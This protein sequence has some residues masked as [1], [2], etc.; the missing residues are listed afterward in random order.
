MIPPL[1]RPY[2]ASSRSIALAGALAVTVAAIA[3]AQGITPDYYAGMRW[4]SI[5]P[6]RSGYVAAVAGIPGDPNTYYVG[7]P[8]GGVWKTTDGGTVWNPIFDSVHVA[9]VGAVAVAPS[10]PNTVYVGTGNSS[11]WSFTPGDGVYKSTDAGATWTNI[12]L[13][14]SQ[15][16][17]A[18]VVDPRQAN[19]VLVAVQGGRGAEPPG[20]HERGVYRSTDGGHDWTRVLGDDATGASDLSY[21]FDDPSIIY[22]TM[23][24]AGAGGRGGGAPAAPSGGASTGIYRSADGG[25]TWKPIGGKGLPPGAAGFALAVASGTHGNR[26]YG[27]VRGGA[28]GGGGPGGLYRSDDGGESWTLGTSA[29]ASAGGHIYADPKNPDV[30]YLMGTSMYRSLDGGKHFVS[31]MGAPSGAD[32]RLLWIDPT[33]PRRMIAGADQG[34]TIS[35]DGGETWNGWYNMRNGQFYRVSTDNDFPYHVCGPQQDSGDACVVSRSDFGQI[36]PSDWTP[37]GG[38]ENGFIATDPLNPRW[39]YDQG[40]YHVLQRFDRK[41]SEIAILYTPTPT[42]RFGGA[43]PLVFSPQNPHLL[44]MGA[45]YVMASSDSARTWRHLSPDLTVRHTVGTD[46]TQ[47]AVPG[48][49]SGPVVGGSIQSLAP[50]TLKAGEIWVGTGNGL[51]QMTRDGG[52]TWHDVTPP[53][54]P[55]GG[56]NTIDPSHSV[57]G[58]AYV[59]L[60]S[61]DN[62]PH[63]YRTADFGTTWK[64]ID[65]GIADGG[66]ARVM[67]EDPVNPDLLYAGTVTG[68]WVSFD[69]GDHWQS[70]QINLPTTVISDMTVHGSDLVISTYG[71]GFWILDDV[72]PLRQAHDVVAA[73]GD[74]FLYRPE[75][76]TH[77]RWDNTQD[78]PLPPEVTVGQNPPEGVIIDYFLKAPVR[79]PITVTFSDPAGHVIREFSNAAPPPDTTM[80]NVPP[81]WIKPATILSTEPGM[82]RFAWDLR[83]PSPSVLNYGYTGTLLDYTEFTVSWHAI[84]G[85]TP[86]TV[87]MGPM[88][89]P[90]RY[91]VTLSAGDQHLTRTFAV[92]PDPRVPVSQAAIVAQVAFERRMSAGLEASNKGFMTVAHFHDWLASDIKSGDPA[93]RAAARSFDSTLTL[94]ANAPQGGFGSLNRDLARR[95]TDMEYGEVMPTA[96]VLAAVNGNCADLQ[97][98]L[99]K[100]NQVQVQRIG[101]L[102]AERKRVGGGDLLPVTV[103]VTGCGTGR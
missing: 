10:S 51:V 15:Y 78:T 45:Q 56:I 43:P 41:T 103:P 50:S 33:N 77:A 55:A 25:V 8:E 88:I 24:R 87:P 61:R 96:S 49:R 22:A 98:A 57:D 23:Q 81:Y 84:P 94:L 3:S 54:M 37:V 40:W 52:L 5:G 102:D 47:I 100:L 82:H 7:L 76:A 44:Y 90:G 66:T 36:R 65:N 60:L 89:A 19:T 38:F 73:T 28:R 21:D 67:R 27:E 29:I 59:A 69:R 53:G 80:I 35:V 20:D 26:L 86:R 18:I 4:R 39:V 93:L 83:Y 101:D 68:T 46:S 48:R 6:N 2:R 30:A 99:V 64:E 42:D 70:L 92:T 1:T 85:N 9:S 32:I 31:Y 71:R 12:G 16:T 11:G 95:L 14:N 63:L 91:T 62:H 13:H 75:S 74:A 58:T 17:S 72:T 34:P 79:G 97:R